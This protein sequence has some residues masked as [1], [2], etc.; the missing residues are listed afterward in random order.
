MTQIP[1]TP[2]RPDDCLAEDWLTFL[3]HRWNALV[4]WQLSDGPRRYSEL[5]G[6]LPRV[7]PKVLTERLGGLVTRGL[8]QRN[9]T[10][11]FP[12]EVTYA[13]TPQGIGLRGIL[14]QLYDWADQQNEPA[15]KESTAAR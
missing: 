5:Q 14:T 11:G 10:N 4:L 1:T 12:R 3:G 15:E 7:S 8:V 6:R 2:C 13:L 9:E